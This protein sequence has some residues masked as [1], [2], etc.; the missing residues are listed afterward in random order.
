M[1]DHL[2]AGSTPDWLRQ[3]AEAMPNRLALLTADSR[4][5]FSQLD[6][7]AD[8]TATRLAAG[9]RP[10]QVVALLAGNSAA[11]VQA[12]HA[13][14]RIGAILLPLNTRLSSAEITWQLGDAGARCVLI[15]EANEQV[16]G[17]ISRELPDL[18]LISLSDLAAT[19]DAFSPSPR[20]ERG[21]GRE[22][23]LDALQAIVYTSGTTGQPKGAMLT[24]GNQL[25][26]AFASALNLGLLPDDRWLACLPLFHVGGLAILLRS[27]IYGTA[28]IVHES[29]DPGRVNRAIDEDGVT[30]ISVVANMLQRMLDGRGATPYPASL[31][32][33][34]LGGGPAPQPL[35]ERCAA[36]AVPVVQTYGL[37]E[38]ASQV[39][40]LA[41]DDALARLGSAGKP[42]FGTELR[43]VGADGQPCAAGEAGEILVKGPTVCAGY[44]KRPDETARALRD[45]WLHT[46]DAGYRDEEGY[47]YVLDRRDDLIVSGGENVYPAEIEAALLAHEAVLEAGVYGAPDEGWGRVPVAVVVLRTGAVVSSE[48][49]MAFC[50]TRLAAYKAPK[51]VE[52]TDALPRNAAGKLLR[53]ELGES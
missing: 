42:L 46:G 53:R 24:F 48:E 5:T 29:F 11:Y 43:I 17:Q 38:A 22:V 52:F 34:L 41:P 16:A 18:K 36:L 33:V 31:R 51:R 10:K 47:L 23:A 44:L 35:L 2:L 37:T 40:T 13:I 49:L 30:I 12:V 1:I 8:Y 27:A 45:G 19:P 28:A 3:R 39:A 15:D 32:C 6:A 50:R 7:A 21:S 4:L 25:W 9:I 20:K 14:A 26:S